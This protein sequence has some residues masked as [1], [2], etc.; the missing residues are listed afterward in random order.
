[1]VLHRMQSQNRL[2]EA[3]LSRNQ[4][5]IDYFNDAIE[6]ANETVD[7]CNKFLGKKL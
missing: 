3:I 5:A 1:M 2:A 6:F 4:G 7:E